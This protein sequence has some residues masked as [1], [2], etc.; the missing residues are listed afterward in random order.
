[1]TSSFTALMT[2]T[3]GTL[4]ELHQAK[5][6][7]SG[8]PRDERTLTWIQNH[9]WSKLD[10]FLNSY[11]EGPP[12]DEWD[13]PPLKEEEHRELSKTASEIMRKL[14]DTSP[15]GLLDELQKQAKSFDWKT[16][17]LW[18]EEPKLHEGTPSSS[19][20]RQAKR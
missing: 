5:K 8:P 16:Y 1:M 18:T 12:A 15:D 20:D 2:R 7:A 6:R 14:N 13:L 19:A 9:P 4:L 3:L 10:S 11:L 17:H